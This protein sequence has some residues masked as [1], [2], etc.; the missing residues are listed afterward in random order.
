[1][2]GQVLKTFHV[3]KIKDMVLE[4]RLLN[5]RDLVEALGTSLGSVNDILG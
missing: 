3:A 2:V 4:E 5:E 1:M